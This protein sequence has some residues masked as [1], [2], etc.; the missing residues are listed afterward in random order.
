MRARRRGAGSGN[1]GKYRVD[2]PGQIL[3]VAARLFSERGYAAVTLKDIVGEAKV[4][5][6]AANYHFG[7]KRSLYRAVIER[8]LVEREEVAPLR[9]ALDRRTP[10]E[11]R[12]RN[13]I[14]SLMTQLLGDSMPSLM[15][16]L[17]LR[18][19]IEPTAAFARAVDALPR[20]QLGILDDIIGELAP[21]GTRR[22]AV[23]RMSISVLGQCVYY[24]YGEKM[25]RRIDP[26]L[27]YSPRA[28]KAI[29]RH[30]HAFSLAAIR[31]MP[32][33]GEP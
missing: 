20:R 31:G 1:R 3:D 4:N 9:S 6:A 2:T 27:R 21:R 11:Q 19:A 25:L 7:D 33:G 29:A 14:E 24:R 12:L 15:S 18:E 8:G 32:P 13:F 5:G 22:S 28:V 30:V 16:R 17:M 23:R 10:A 26:K